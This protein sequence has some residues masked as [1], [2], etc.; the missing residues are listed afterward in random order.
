MR[1]TISNGTSGT[2]TVVKFWQPFFFSFLMPI[3]VG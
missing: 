1:A 2:P 3:K